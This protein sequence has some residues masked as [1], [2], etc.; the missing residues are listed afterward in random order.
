MAD[1]LKAVTLDI[2]GRPV[3]SATFD[4]QLSIFV[5][6]STFKITGPAKTPIQ[7][8]PDRRNAGSRQVGE[9]T[10]NG[11]ISWTNMIVGSSQDDCIERVEALIAQAEE[12]QG[13]RLIEWRPDG[14]SRTSYYEIRGT[15]GWMPLYDW[16]PFAGSGVMSVELTVPIAPLARGLP[17]DILDIF[18]VDTRGDYTYD[19]GAAANEEV[20][21]GELK[22]AANLSTE[23][24][25]IHA[26]RGYQYA[27]NQQTAKYTPGATITGWK[28][29]VVLKRI[30]A[31][32][33]LETY[34]E[35]NGTNSILKIDKVVA[36]ARTTLNS[37]N[38]PARVKNGTAFWIRARIEGNLITPEYFTATPTP[39]SAPA[40]NLTW[41]LAGGDI[42]TFGAGVK[43]APGRVWIPKTAGAACD[44]YAVEPY[45]Y[46]NATLPTS[47]PL[48][49]TV[50]GDAP[51][52]ADV[53]VT[54]SGGAAAPIWALLAW[55]KTPVAGLAQA[56]L[57]IIEA[58]TAGNLAGWAIEANAFAR[59]G[60]ALI[61]KAAAATD[62]YTASWEID[63][64]LLA[65][66]AFQSEVAVEVW[67]RVT[68]ANTIVT[69][70][71]TVSTRPQDGTSY[72]SSRYTDEWG[73][74]GKLLVTPSAGE[75]WRFLRLGT[76]R[77]LVDTTRPRIWLLWLSG[78]VGAGTSGA[79]GVDYLMLVPASSRACGPSSKP[80]DGTFPPFVSSTAETSKVIRCDLSATVAKPPAYG[81]PDHG[82]GGQ[83]LEIPPGEVTLVAKLS[84]LAPDDPTSDAT[85]EQ[86]AHS[87]TVHA[88]VTPRWNLFRSGN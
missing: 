42:A 53:T 80:N 45:T 78:S 39:M 84:S 9:T 75:A 66:D 3:V 77:L 60:K 69:P 30:S 49:G 79:W 25:A 4:D 38:L 37:T 28:S 55:A 22:A 46:R 65:A 31:T 8:T 6:R 21:G 26:A 2:G 13:K 54:P 16:A 73:S 56:P 32:T 63:P 23:N 35:D 87:A 1:I 74:A 14:S 88:A 61:D 48:G 33:Y 12:T 59:G 51:A 76:L 17:L 68:L 11:S 43:G 29:G 7:S 34:I 81:H 20:T 71:L 82:L 27:D 58:E 24:R 70:T 15:Y 52:L 86:L 50:P 18:T 36:S 19:S 67:A 44:E 72:G 83:L 5:T 64:S 10:D 62:T 57:G 85:T 47:L 41:T 40:W